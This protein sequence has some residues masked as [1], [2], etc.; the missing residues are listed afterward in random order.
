MSDH[1]IQPNAR[2]SE[3]QAGSGKLDEAEKPTPGENDPQWLPEPSNAYRFVKRLL[4]V[5]V[6]L[7]SL[8]ILLPAMVVIAI[9]VRLT[10]EGPV[11][12]RLT[13]LGYHGRPFTLLKF[14]TMYSDQSANVHRE[15]VQ[16]LID[17]DFHGKDR[18][19][20]IS[21]DPRVTPLGSLLRR[22]SLDELPQFLNVLRGDLSLVGPSAPMPYEWDHYAVGQKLRLSCKPGVTS[23]WMVTGKKEMTF[24]EM[25][26]L[27]IEYARHPSILS[28]LRILLLTPL[29]VLEDKAAY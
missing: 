1:K 20:S 11:F 3:S 22:V 24:D 21:D 17:G 28:D 19:F 23:L 4:D 12:L 5:V 16:R 29:A 15:Y 27:D 9:V 14:R 7:L 6:S 26:R 13:R 25:V 8:I 2:V 10:S 18:S